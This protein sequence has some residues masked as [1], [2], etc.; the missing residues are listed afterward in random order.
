MIQYFWDNEHQDYFNEYVF[1][2][3]WCRLGPLFVGVL[4]SLLYRDSITNENSYGYKLK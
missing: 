3:L 4:F 2:T 1:E